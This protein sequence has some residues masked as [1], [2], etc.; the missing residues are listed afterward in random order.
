[1]S[2]SGLHELV[3]A[4]K[5]GAEV[6]VEVVLREPPNVVRRVLEIVGIDDAVTVV[7]PVPPAPRRLWR[8]PAHPERSPA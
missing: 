8:R 1:M 7:P 3:D 6:G 2:S 4:C 5:V